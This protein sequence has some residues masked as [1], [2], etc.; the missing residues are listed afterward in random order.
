MLRSKNQTDK[1]KAYFHSA[2]AA[3][4]VGIFFS[5]QFVLAEGVDVLGGLR[6]TAKQ[7]GLFTKDATLQSSIGRVIGF[8]LAFVGVIFFALIV[9]G[10]FLWMTAAGNPEQV[11]KAKGLIV[12]S[13]IGLVI[14]LAAYSITS[15]IFSGITAATVK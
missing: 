10:G 7:G 14:I 5:P 9:Y 13:I 11:K 15:F 1:I 6:T 12:N 4:A 8:V 2:L 3:L